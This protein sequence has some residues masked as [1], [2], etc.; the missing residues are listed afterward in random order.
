MVYQQT[1]AGGTSLS[2]IMRPTE[3][4]TSLQLLALDFNYQTIHFLGWTKMILICPSWYLLVTY[5]CRSRCFFAENITIYHNRLHIFIYIYYP[6]EIVRH[7]LVW[8]ED[9]YLQFLTNSMALKS[10]T[11]RTFEYAKLTTMKKNPVFQWCHELYP[12]NIDIYIY[13]YIYG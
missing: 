13:I 2:G 1:L 9:I 5:S 12:H 8:L 4:A 7:G 10:L 3:R 11:P 6:Q